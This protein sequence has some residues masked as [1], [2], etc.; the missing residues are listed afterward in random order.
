[1]GGG[2]ETHIWHLKAKLFP[3]CLQEYIPENNFWFSLFLKRAKIA[4][5]EHVP[6]SFTAVR[7]V[8]RACSWSPEEVRY[9][10]KLIHVHL[11]CFAWGHYIW[12]HFIATIRVKTQDSGWHHLTM[13][14][15][16]HVLWAQW[17]PVIINFNGTAPVITICG[18]SLGCS[19]KEW[20]PAAKFQL[21]FRGFLVNPIFQLCIVQESGNTRQFWV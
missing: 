15:L 18:A 9:H 3:V 13:L 19:Y 17:C 4:S 14:G 7:Q 21:N 8:T 6:L 5:M 2:E 1:M 10:Q 20:M 11:P 12:C 16:L